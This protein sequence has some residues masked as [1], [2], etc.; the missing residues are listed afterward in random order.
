M[1][2]AG[3]LTVARREL[4][5]CVDSAAA[6]V[7]HSLLRAV[8]GESREGGERAHA[9]RGNEQRAVGSGDDSARDGGAQRQVL[10]PSVSA[11]ARP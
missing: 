9:R 11:V 1:R 3:G 8:G 7:D 10:L 6:D 2:A 4:A 5:R